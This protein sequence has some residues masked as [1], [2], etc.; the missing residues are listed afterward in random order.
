LKGP[1]KWGFVVILGVGEKIFGGKVH[2]SSEFCVFRHLWSR[3][4]ARVVALYMGIAICRD[5]LKFDFGFG[6]SAETDLKCSFG[7]ISVTVITPHFTFGFGC[8]YTADD[9]NWS[10]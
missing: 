1:P 9:R 5:R 6:F 4:D 10:E 2:P 7:S 8:K 3:S